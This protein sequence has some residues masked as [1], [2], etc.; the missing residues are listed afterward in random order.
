[1]LHSEKHF[2]RVKM[3]SRREILIPSTF[4][5]EKSIFQWKRKAPFDTRKKKKE[6]ANNIKENSHSL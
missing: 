6:M 1:M 2:K 4:D 5:R 3:V